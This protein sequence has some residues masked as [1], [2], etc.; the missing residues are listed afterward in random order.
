MSKRKIGIA[1]GVLVLLIGGTVWALMGRADAQVEKLKQM[2]DDLFANGRPQPDQFDQF[3]KEMDQLSPEQRR[4]V[5]DQAGEQMQRRMDKR[6]DDY[7]ALPPDKRKDFLDKQIPGRGETPKGK[8]SAP[9]ARRTGRT[10]PAAGG[11][12]PQRR[13]RR[14]TQGRRTQRQSRGAKRTPQS[15]VRQFLARPAGAAGGLF[16]RLAEPPR[17]TRTALLARTRTPWTLAC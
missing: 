7:F 17:R 9:R 15:A 14:R 10:R 3:R 8:R 5:R 11:P 16:R 4:Q 6:I 12:K 13:Q 1:V 2:Q